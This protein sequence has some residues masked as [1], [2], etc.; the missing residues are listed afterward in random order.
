MTCDEAVELISVSLDGELA[1]P[2]IARL[3]QHLA[4]CESCQAARA[5]EAWLSSIIAAGALSEEPPDALRRRI[6]ERV[7][8]EAARASLAP[9][10]R[11]P[12]TLLPAALGAMAVGIAP[13]LAIRALGPIGTPRIL[14]DA[15]AG[16]WEYAD[17]ATLLDVTGDARRLEQWARDHLGLAVRL[18]AD[19]GGGQAPV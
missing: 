5:A 17:D 4:A 15:V 13:F 11:W 8:V 10:R 16:H 9:R 19:A 6:R 12:R 14:A 3:E 7:A 18:P 1:V 2:D